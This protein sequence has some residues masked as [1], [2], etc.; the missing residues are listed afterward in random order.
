MERASTK[1]MITDTARAAKPA[2]KKG[3]TMVSSR[4]RGWL[5]GRA[6]TRVVTV[7]ETLASDV[8]SVARDDK[9]VV[10]EDF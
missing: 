5:R 7:D 2:Q 3:R 8:R 6:M 10:V 9:E 4:P 1:A